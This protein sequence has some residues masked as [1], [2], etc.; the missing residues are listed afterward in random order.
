[1]LIRQISLKRGVT[2]KAAN[3]SSEH[4][5]QD[6][7]T[8]LEIPH[9]K[10]AI[11]LVGGAGGI[12]LLDKFPMRKAVGI[13]AKLAEETDSVVVDGGTHAG[14]MTDRKSVV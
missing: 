14:I 8:G 4:E 6:A 13:V 3:I 9:P 5:I 12:G 11:V 2:V 1:M 7:L 10:N